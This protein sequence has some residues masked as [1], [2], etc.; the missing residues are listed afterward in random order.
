LGEK[1]RLDAK[2]VNMITWS[3]SANYWASYWQ[4]THSYSTNESIPW[5]LNIH[6]TYTLTWAWKLENNQ[7]WMNIQY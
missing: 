5:A 6:Q 7:L 3:I 1:R 2:E 4:V